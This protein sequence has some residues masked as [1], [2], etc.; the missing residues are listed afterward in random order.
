MTANPHEEA[1][2]ARKVTAL[3]LVLQ[4]AGATGEIAARFDIGQRLI[5][6]QAAR[7]KPPSDET[8]AQVVQALA[9]HSK[10]GDLD[11]RH[12]LGLTA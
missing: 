3:T 9:T 1:A 2:R 11:A 5:A 10:G 4:D 8:W 12:Q 6:A 7:V